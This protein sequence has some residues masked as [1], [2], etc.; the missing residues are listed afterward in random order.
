MSRP[1]EATSVAIMTFFCFDMKERSATSRSRWSLSP[2]ISVMR[3]SRTCSLLA[4]SW[5]ALF[6]DTKTMASSSSPSCSASVSSSAWSLSLGL[7][8][9]SACCVTSVFAFA[10][11]MSP[12]CTCTGRRRKSKA[13]WRTAFGQVALKS[14]VWRSAPRGQASTI[15][16]IWGSKPMSSMR[17]ASSSTA[18][19]TWPSQTCLCSRNSLSLPGVATMTWQPRLSHSSCS[20]FGSPPVTTQQRMPLERPNFSASIWICC[21]SSRV[22]A[23][24]STMGPRC[25]SAPLRS[26]CA[27][28]GPRNASVL[29]LPLL[30]MPMRS[31]PAARIG[32]HWAWMGVGSTKPACSISLCTSG[33]KLE[34]SKVW[35]GVGTALLLKALITCI[36]CRRR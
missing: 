10:A 13:S 30:A 12:M 34:P 19:L 27:K 33:G 2:W 11:F 16:R 1:R 8:R 21:A 6:V 25:A 29:P 35:I 31:W 24:T 14:R 3:K 9:S 36:S 7:S 28:P 23:S 20:P 5:H 18:K 22:G 32:Q 4:T 26:T 15:L 17:S